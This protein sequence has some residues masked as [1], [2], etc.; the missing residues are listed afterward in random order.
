MTCEVYECEDSSKGV[1]HRRCLQRS[2]TEY[3]AISYNTTTSQDLPEKRRLPSKHAAHTHNKAY[4][5][6]MC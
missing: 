2:K 5:F 6:A 4:R 3:K 1:V